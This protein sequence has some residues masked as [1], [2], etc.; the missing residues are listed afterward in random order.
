MS[1]KLNYNT[2]SMVLNG[3]FEDSSYIGGVQATADDFEVY[4][5]IPSAPDAAKF[6]HL[7]RWY[8]TMTSTKALA[9]ATEGE[10]SK[11]EEEDVDEDF[12]LFGSDD[13]EED[14]EAE[15]LKAQ[16]LAEYH[17]KKAAKGPAPVEK[18][19]AIFHVKPWDTD[20]DL[21]EM[22]KHVRTISMDGL[23]W[24]QGA[25]R[26]PVAFGIEM[27]EIYGVVEEK[28]STEELIELIEQFEDHVMSADMVSLSKA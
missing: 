9:P 16:R 17:A 21:R 24:G 2:L 27:L 5:S 19:I 12:E 28:V 1:A 14:E 15:K 10:A 26:I 3:Y 13:E 18:S 20:T 4:Q 23:V 6:P 8:K 11:T 25:K 22:E 7:A